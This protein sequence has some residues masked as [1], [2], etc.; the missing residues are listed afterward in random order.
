LPL[1]LLPETNTVA[2]IYRSRSG[3][4]RERRVV[5][6]WT[7]TDPVQVTARSVVQNAVDSDQA[8][9]D[10]IADG[11]AVHVLLVEE[12]SGSIF[13]TYSGAIGRWSE[14]VLQVEGID[15]P[16]IRGARV[17]TG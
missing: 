9:A 16:W 10:A 6:P 4:L 15:G 7:L 14:P 5:D 3:R 12:G 1:I 11:S 13:H 17:I 2:V 8:G